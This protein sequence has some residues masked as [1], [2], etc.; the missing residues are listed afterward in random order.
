MSQAADE[1]S[2]QNK[3]KRTYLLTYSSIDPAIFP[4]R[5]SFGE[6]CAEAFG[7]CVDYYAVCKE[8][9]EN[10]MY[11]YHASFKLTKPKRWGEPKKYL[12]N[13]YNVVINFREPDENNYMYVGA[14]RYVTKE[15]SQVYHSQ[16]HPPLEK[17]KNSRTNQCVR[18]YVQKRKSTSDEKS[19]NGKKPTEKNQKNKRR[20]MMSNLELC[21][22]IIKH[23]I[24]S[25][26]E[27]YAIANQRRAD[28]EPDLAEYVTKYPKKLNENIASAWKLHD[29]VNEVKRQSMP[30]MERVK[31]AAIEPCVTNCNGEWYGC[32]TQV[33]RKNNI[34]PIVFASALRKLLVEGRGKYRNILITGPADCGKTFILSPITKIFPGTLV[35]PSSTKY[36]WIGADEAEIIFL[37]DYRYNRDQI[38]WDDLLRLLEGAMVHL[39]APMNHFA[40]DICVDSD[41]PILATSIGPVRRKG[42][43]DEGEITMMDARW[44]IIS[45]HHV[46]PQTEQ[47]TVPECGSCFAKLV[48]NGLEDM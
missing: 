32:A 2:T 28:G 7:D 38:E 12:M 36:A 30:R 35:S 23:K 22:F 39:P 1:F 40:K 21:D 6:A 18:A 46:I 45:F 47:K 42:R 3:P 37:N 43:N 5:Q 9:H 4:S 33:L 29:S 8:K 10:G 26:K 15:D 14:Y 25:E 44:H 48:L 34:H 19:E 31:A 11:H 16:E 27:L 20:R 17:I 41:V 24:R 13:Q